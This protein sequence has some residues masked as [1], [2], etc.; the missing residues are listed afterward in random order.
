MHWP[1]QRLQDLH[2][3]LRYATDIMSSLVI[4]NATQ[5]FLIIATIAWALLLRRSNRKL[6]E[7]LVA[8]RRQSLQD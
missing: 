5:V 4:V 7:R 6:H 3:M 8:A 1:I 2:L